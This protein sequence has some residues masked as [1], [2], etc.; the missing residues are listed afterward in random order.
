MRIVQWEMGMDYSPTNPF[1]QWMKVIYTGNYEGMMN[2]LEGMSDIEV[3]MH[4]GMRS[5]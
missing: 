3:M 2:I 4:L 1:S 5:L